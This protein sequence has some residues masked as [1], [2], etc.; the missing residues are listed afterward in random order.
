MKQI[1]RDLYTSGRVWLTLSHGF[2]QPTNDGK[3]DVDLIKEWNGYLTL[4]AGAL[5]VLSLWEYGKKAPNKFFIPEYKIEEFRLILLQMLDLKKDPRYIVD[6]RLTVEGKPTSLYYRLSLSNK[7]NIEVY[8]LESEYNG[9]NLVN[10]A[11]ECEGVEYAMYDAN[12]QELADVIPSSSE[13]VK[14]K[15]DAAM[16]A[17]LL[18]VMGET[19]VTT[20]SKERSTEGNTQRQAP[21]SIPKRPEPQ[22]IDRS[23]NFKTAT[24]LL[25]PE[26]ENKSHPVNP[27]PENT[28]VE[29]AFNEPDYN[30]DDVYDLDESEDT[31]VYGD[32]DYSDLLEDN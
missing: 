6:N 32:T 16:M 26:E 30:E 25:T 18:K 11:I 12:V 21:R 17:Y 4:N 19:T 22:K 3:S 10:I 15:Q 1:S 20:P 2:T 27:I 29:K 13:I 31:Y 14:Y 7:K 8:F 23:G 5:F 24:E 28:K 9:E